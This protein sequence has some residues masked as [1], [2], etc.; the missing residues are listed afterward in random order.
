M[1]KEAEQMLTTAQFAEHYKV[2]YTTIMAWLQREIIPGARRV[3]RPRG[4][5]WEMPATAV[6]KFTPPKQGR[7]KK[8]AASKKAAAKKSKRGAN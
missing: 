1:K 5:V 3:P 6:A 4:D 7:P 8:E 2:A